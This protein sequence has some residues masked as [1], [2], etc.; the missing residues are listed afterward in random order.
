MYAPRSVIP[1]DEWL[2]KTSLR[3]FERQQ[4][5]MARLHLPLSQTET[6]RILKTTTERLSRDAYYIT[7]VAR[8]ILTDNI[9]DKVYHEEEVLQAE[10]ELFKALANA[11]EAIDGVLRSAARRIGASGFKEPAVPDNAPLFEVHIASNVVA[12]FLNLL[13]KADLYFLQLNFL[14]QIGELSDT[15]EGAIQAKVNGT[16][17]VRQRVVHIVAVA[18]KQFNRLRSICNRIQEERRNRSQHR[19]LEAK[20]RPRK[21]APERLPSDLIIIRP[22][23]ARARRNG[24][25]PETPLQSDASPAVEASSAP[26]KLDAATDAPAP[27]LPIAANG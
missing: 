7:V 26:E 14:W 9:S 3:F 18:G 24:A 16:R 22:E 2:P 13:A 12:E 6:V 11:N 17:A 1:Q 8:E 23:K 10:Q 19:K 5:P 21:Q 25:E 27:P 15:P 20:K 4:V